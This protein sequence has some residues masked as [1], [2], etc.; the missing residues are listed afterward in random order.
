MPALAVLTLCLVSW[1]RIVDCP[2][3]FVQPGGLLGLGV[4]ISFLELA[5]QLT[6][7]HEGLP[8]LYIASHFPTDAMGIV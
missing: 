8:W 5:I 4:W 2:E 1:V 7:I 3:A 6:E